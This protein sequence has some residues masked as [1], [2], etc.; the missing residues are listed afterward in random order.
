MS[1]HSCALLSLLAATAARLYTEF[2][3]GGCHLGCHAAL[4]LC[5]VPGDL[6]ARFAKSL[7]LC[8]YFNLSV[9]TS[10]TTHIFEEK[11]GEMRENGHRGETGAAKEGQERGRETQIHTERK[12]EASGCLRRL[13]AQAC[14]LPVQL[15]CLSP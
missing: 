5:R 12:K 3:S 10:S 9:K 7:T 4:L 8:F 2:R 6:V 13:P 11:T 14:L 1:R 15:D